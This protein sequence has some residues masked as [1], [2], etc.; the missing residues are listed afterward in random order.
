MTLRLYDF[1]CPQHGLFEDLVNTQTFECPC[2][3][4][5]APARRTISPVRINLLAMAT[6]SSAS[7]ESINH[8][9]KIHRQ[10]KAIEDRCFADNGD[11]GHAPGCDTGRPLTPEDAQR[12]GN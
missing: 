2:P 9:E 4:C 8:F 5:N 12:L 11:Y 1:E 6:S 10:R 7:P 3:K